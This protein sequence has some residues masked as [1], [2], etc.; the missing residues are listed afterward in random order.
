MKVRL[1]LVKSFAIK[2]RGEGRPN[3]RVQPTPLAASEIVAILKADFGSKVVSI[4]RCGA[5]DAQSVGRLGQRGRHSRSGCKSR[6]RMRRLCHARRAGARCA[7]VVRWPVVRR[8]RCG[9]RDR[10]LGV[11]QMSA[12]RAA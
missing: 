11:V 10:V 8:A 3:P 5:A 6:S 1:N 7:G 12:R 4:Y 9:Q 2:S